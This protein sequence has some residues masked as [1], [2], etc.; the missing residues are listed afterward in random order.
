[1]TALATRLRFEVAGLVALI[2]C[3]FGGPSG[4][5]T[6]YVDFPDVAQDRGSSTPPGDETAVLSGDEGN[7]ATGGDENTGDA[8]MTVSSSDD[9]SDGAGGEASESDASRTVTTEGGAC[10]APVAVCDPVHNT[11]C[12]A[13]QQCDVDTSQT[14]TATGLC[15]FAS[16][17]EGGPCLST[18]FT[19]SCP[20]GFT[21]VGSDCRELCFCDSD[22][23]AGQCCSDTSGPAGF[24]LCRPCR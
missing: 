9:G 6:Q 7:G 12:N 1:M 4:D 17:A 14:T 24:T 15:V 10:S 23:P 8:S 13:F 22:C 21:C 18:I 11:G 19:E 5:P 16:S 3:R 2:G 20:Q